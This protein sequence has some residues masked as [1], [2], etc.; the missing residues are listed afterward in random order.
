MKSPNFKTTLL[1]K[2]I[3]TCKPNRHYDNVN[4]VLSFLFISSKERLY[5]YYIDDCVSLLCK[6]KDDEVV[7]LRIDS[8]LKEFLPSLSSSKSTWKMSDTGIKLSN[9]DFMIKCELNQ[10]SVPKYTPRINPAMIESNT[11]DLDCLLPA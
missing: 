6:Y 2:L 5:V 7:G 10:R 1:S 3:V 8:F 4:D 11:V 9:F